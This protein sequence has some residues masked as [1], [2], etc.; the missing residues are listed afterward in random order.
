MLRQDGRKFDRADD[1]ARD[2]DHTLYFLEPIIGSFSEEFLQTGVLWNAVFDFEELESVGVLRMSG[3]ELVLKEL[4]EFDAILAVDDNDG[5]YS[6]R[7]TVHNFDWLKLFQLIHDE[8]FVP[9]GQ[10]AEG[11]IHG[12]WV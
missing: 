11:E 9:H 1:I 3:D 5:S 10:V 2:N 12:D 8:F 6:E 4:L 7:S